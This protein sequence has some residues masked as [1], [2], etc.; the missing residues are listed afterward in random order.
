LL[1]GRADPPPSPAG[2][3][4]PHLTPRPAPTFHPIVTRLPHHPALDAHELVAFL[5]RRAVAGIEAVDDGT[6]RRSLRLP[7]GA[8]ILALTPHTDHVACELDLD[9]PRDKPQALEAARGKLRLDTD[10]HAIA[11]RLGDDP[12]LGALVRQA[13]GRR[14]PGHHDPAELAV[15]AVLGQQVSVEAAATLAARLVAAHGEP[16]KRPAFGVSHV[17]PAPD[18]LARLDPDR[19]PMPRARGRVLVA[20]GAAREIDPDSLLALPG[21][22]PWTASYVALR[23]FADDDAFLPTDLGVRRGLEAL[24]KDPRAAAALAEA[25]RPLRGFAL[26][27]LWAAAATR[28]PSRP[29]PR[30]RA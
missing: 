12:I 5:A 20:I 28:P 13:P 16:L 22:G 23:A 18:A 3:S 19:L 8:G 6:Y 25:W 26:A 14:I 17:F 30:A 7:H 24:G 27:H 11:A 21:V 4:R 10:P 2:V 9:D 29:S 15:R 1:P